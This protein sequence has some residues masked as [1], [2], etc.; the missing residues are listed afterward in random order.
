MAAVLSEA[1]ATTLFAL[2]ILRRDILPVVEEAPQPT[3]KEIWRFHAPLAATTLLTLLAGPITAGAL[4]RLP[5]PADS[6][7]A[8]PVA[9]MVLLV[10]RGWCFALQEITVAQADDEEKRAALKRFTVGVGWATSIGT[11]ALVATPLLSL[12]CRRGIQLR[13]ELYEGVRIAVGIGMFLPLITAM[14][15]WARGLLV[16]AARTQGDLSRHGC[17][18]RD[19]RFYSDVRSFLAKAPAMVLAAVAFTVSNFAEY[20]FLWSK[21]QAIDVEA[22]PLALET[23]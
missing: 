14:S 3:Q 10:M 9:Y 17:Q 12:Y 20:L 19:P 7:A 6:L 22:L 15:S 13:P 4:S 5:N 2:P 16:K 18:S 1:L 23:A 11:L 21:L 8:W